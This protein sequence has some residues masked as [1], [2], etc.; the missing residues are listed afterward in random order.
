MMYQK[1]DHQSSTYRPNT[2]YSDDGYR[3][4]SNNL[5]ESMRSALQERRRNHERGVFLINQL[6]RALN[7]SAEV[8]RARQEDE[9]REFE[10]ARKKAQKEQEQKIQQE[11]QRKQAEIERKKQEEVA[12][13]KLEAEQEICFQQPQL[14][15]IKRTFDSAY[16]TVIVY[17]DSNWSRALTARKE[18]L[19][20]TLQS[21][22]IDEKKYEL[23]EDVDFYFDDETIELLS[24]SRGTQITNALHYEFVRISHYV[25]CEDFIDNSHNMPFHETVIRSIQYGIATLHN[26]HNIVQGSHIADVCWTLQEDIQHAVDVAANSEELMF[27][28]F[29]EGWSGAMG[30]AIKER[31]RFYWN[32]VGMFIDNPEKYVREKVRILKDIGFALSILFNLNYE[33]LSNDYD[34]TWTNADIKDRIDLNRWSNEACLQGWSLLGSEVKKSWE[35]ADQESV[36]KWLGESV[37]DSVVFSLASGSLRMLKGLKSI[38]LAEIFVAPVEHCAEK[39]ACKLHLYSVKQLQ[40]LNSKQITATLLDTLKVPCGEKTCMQL[41]ERFS[42]KYPALS[43]VPTTEEAARKLFALIAQELKPVNFSAED[44]VR[45]ELAKMG[46]NVAA[47]AAEK[48]A[49]EKIVS[50]ALKPSDLL[51]G[52]IINYAGQLY[53]PAIPNAPLE[54]LLPNQSKEF[55]EVLINEALPINEQVSLLT[56]HKQYIKE[57]NTFKKLV[58]EINNKT[59]KQLKKENIIFPLKIMLDPEHMFL[60]RFM[61]ASE[62]GKKLVGMHHDYN[63]EILPKIGCTLKVLETLTHGA[64]YTEVWRNGV[65]MR[66]NK[67]MF[68][69]KL[70]RQEVIQQVFEALDR[71][72]NQKFLEK[73]ETWEIIGQA[74]NDQKIKLLIKPSGM[75]IS[76]YPFYKE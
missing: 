38:K 75:I 12:R 57:I 60:P 10:E 25:C 6:G 65:K 67:T 68:D 41:L 14:Q 49:F 33:P 2:S 8:M 66:E 24:M 21:P 58:K 23:P 3:S 69:P 54:E 62:K 20:S 40:K 35:N 70:T 19:E 5:M 45:Y 18:A 13:L 43:Q 37:V 44:V 55:S 72:I 51:W 53:L 64:Y 63:N 46:K 7:Q 30:A 17:S 9:R 42:L 31:G 71:P 56:I 47:T 73:T 11:Q 48:A 26:N 28:S 1:S 76:A 59:L 61:N 52:P 34:I 15:A 39:E 29:R 32:Q 4:P 74:Q 16:K 22:K 50:T 27:A 36:G